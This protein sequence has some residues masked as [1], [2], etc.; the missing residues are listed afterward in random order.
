MRNRVKIIITILVLLIVGGAVTIFLLRPW[1]A[2]IETSNETFTGNNSA[3]GLFEN[4]SGEIC[5]EVEMGRGNTVGNVINYGR[6]AQSG[7]WIFYSTMHSID[8]NHNWSLVKERTDGSDRQV[9]YTTGNKR[10]MCINV[11]GDWIFFTI[12]GEMY[13]IRTDGTM[14][15]LL[16]DEVG[17]ARVFV[18]DGW[19]FRTVGSGD[20]A[21]M[22][23]MRADG[24]YI[25][26]IHYERGSMASV[27]DGWLYFRISSGG[28][29]SPIYKIRT[30]G[31]EFTQINE[32]DSN[33]PNVVDGWIYYVNLSRNDNIY[34]MRTDGSENQ[35]ITDDAATHI[36]VHDGWIY[37]ANHSNEGYLYRIRTDGTDREQIINYSAFGINVVDDWIFFR[38]GRPGGRGDWHTA[39]VIGNP[40]YRVRIDGTELEMISD[41]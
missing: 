14:S 2:R 35:Q 9:L 17:L 10:I 37:Y 33:W 12:G 18:V 30:D 29:N 20:S 31:N 24:S 1:E 15:E 38:E 25:E 22:H 3:A 23:R 13:R 6:A 7:D 34:K 36:N 27:V 26:Q 19:I 21:R 11:I 32:D 39:E 5:Y 4:T 8:G 16:H 41:E 28:N 40:M